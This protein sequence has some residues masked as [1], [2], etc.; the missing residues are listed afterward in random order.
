MV[1]H[2]ESNAVECV[3]ENLHG[4]YND[5]TGVNHFV[6][7]RSSVDGKFAERL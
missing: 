5:I 1:A 3:G 4:A 6:H 2:L 7:H